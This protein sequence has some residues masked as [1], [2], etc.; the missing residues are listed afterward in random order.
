RSAV[1]VK[2]GEGL[3]IDREGTRAGHQY[4]LLGHIGSNSSGVV[5][6]PYL[7]NLTD[8]SDTFA[9][10]QHDGIEFIHMLEGEVDY[11][12]ARKTYTLEPG[13]SLTF[14]ADSP[15][16]PV[17]LSKLPARYLSIICYPQ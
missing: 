15:H 4:N 13:D 14:D 11:S 9:A 17:K 10:F 7:I 2:A 5:M 12:H 3:E 16:G 8:D 6:E 1:H